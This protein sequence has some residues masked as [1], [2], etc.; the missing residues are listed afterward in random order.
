MISLLPSLLPSGLMLLALPGRVRA[1]ILLP[2]F[3]HIFFKLLHIANLV[4]QLPIP[5]F[6][7]WH[8]A[9]LLL[10]SASRDYL[11]RYRL[12]HVSP[13]ARFARSGAWALSSICVCITGTEADEAAA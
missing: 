1:R 6:N 4:S 10:F 3:I 12:L 9:S 2:G 7:K 5:F 11:S 13:G 8:D